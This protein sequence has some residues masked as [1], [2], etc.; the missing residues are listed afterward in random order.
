MTVPAADNLRRFIVTEAAA[1]AA[2]D[3]LDA[4]AALHQPI[5]ATY[6]YRHDGKQHHADL[7]TVCSCGQTNCSTARLL[8]GEGDRG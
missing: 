1:C 6:L 7:V 2:A 3:L 8:R 5:D 4:I